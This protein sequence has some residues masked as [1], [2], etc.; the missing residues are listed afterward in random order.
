MV[1]RAATHDVHD[2]DLAAGQLQRG[3]Q[4]PAVGQCEGVQHAAGDLHGRGR[5]RLAGLGGQLADAGGHV[6]GGQQPRVVDVDDGPQRGRVLGRGEQRDQPGVLQALVG[7]GAQ[8]LRE[9]PQPHDVLEEAHGA[10]DAALVGE[11]RATGGLGQHRGVELETDERPGARGDVGE[12][13]G[14]GRHAHHRGGGVVGADGDHR[15]SLRDAGVAADLG[16]HRPDDR[17]G[18]AQRR[19]DRPRQPEVAHQVARPVTGGEVVER[20]GRGVGALH[21]DGA[22]QP[23]GQQVRQQQQVLGRLQRRGPLRRHQLVERGERQVLQPGR[24]VEPRRIDGRGDLGRHPLGAG[25]AVGVGVAQ[26]GAVPVQQAVVDGPGVDADAVQRT[27]LGDPA[28]AGQHLSVDA[29][30]VPEQPV[31]HPHPAVGEAVHL[32]QVQRARTDRAGHDPAAGRAQVD[33]GDAQRRARR[34]GA[35]SPGHRRKAAATPAST[36]TCRPVVWVISGPHSTKTALAM[37]E[38]STSRLRIVR[39]A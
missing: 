22:G 39:W 10:V 38:G 8:A 32:L 13:V 5:H 9:H 27:G 34:P 16:E 25:V 17:P 6:T 14:V 19:Q 12:A 31:A 23:V 20:G 1:L 7:P 30:H 2:I 35:T 29:E 37:W 18:L 33:R 28:D 26:Q 36:G 24:R 4:V 3:A 15:N 21:A 11:V